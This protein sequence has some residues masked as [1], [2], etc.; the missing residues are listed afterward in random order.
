MKPIAIPEGDTAEQEELRPKSLERTTT[1][2]NTE[3]VTNRTEPQPTESPQTQQLA[4]VERNEPVDLGPPTQGEVDA[5]ET[6]TTTEQVQDMQPSNDVPTATTPSPD[7]YVGAE[8]NIQDILE[9]E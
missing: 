7:Q 9:E 2:N 4:T 1:A 6:P 8:P 5:M 3:E